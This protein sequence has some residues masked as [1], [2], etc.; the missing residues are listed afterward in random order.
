MENFWLKDN[1]TGAIYSVVVVTE[2]AKTE[3][4]KKAS[5]IGLTDYDVL[6]EAPT[7]IRTDEEKINRFRE[8]TSEVIDSV[9]MLAGP[10][11]FDNILSAVSYAADDQDSVNQPH[12]IALV[13]YRRN[14]WVYARVQLLAWQKGGPEPTEKEFLAGMP[15]YREIEDKID[16]LRI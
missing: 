11:G 7:I 4:E 5:I 8:L 2:D 12:A 13:A 14:C 9:A 1:V 16:L 10:F 15:E 6:D 3:L